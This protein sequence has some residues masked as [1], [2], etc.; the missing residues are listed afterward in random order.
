M[1]NRTRAWRRAQR[2]RMLNRAKNMDWI[3]WWYDP[4]MEYGSEQYHED[5]HQR[6]S[7]WC[8]ILRPCSC[9]MCGNQRHNDWQPR[10]EMMTMAERK[11]EDDFIDQMKDVDLND[12]KG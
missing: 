1:S 4:D 6:A 11:A 9:Y 7:R 2:A 10:R 5:L 12:T 8:D 3:R